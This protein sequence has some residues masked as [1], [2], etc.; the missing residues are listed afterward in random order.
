MR[1]TTLSDEARDELSIRSD[2]SVRQAMQKMNETGRTLLLVV[3]G[4]SLTGVVA[5]GD[6]RRHLA[7]GG[8][9]D[10]P[11]ESAVNRSPITL[12]ASTPV[13]DVRAFMVRRGLEFVPLVANGN[14]VALSILERAPRATD[15]SAVVMAG[16]L[17][18]RLSPLTDDCPKPLLPLDGR[19]ILSHIVEH[20]R[21]QGIHRF[22]FSV[23]HLSNMIV[24]H[25]DDGSRWDCYIDYVH[26]AQRLG[27]GGS[28]SLVDP[29]AL[30]DPFLCVNGDVLSDV[31]IGALRD[32]H[33][34]RSWDATMVVRGYSHTVPYGVVE[35]DDL[36]QYLGLREKPVQSFQVNAGIYM[37]S[38]SVLEIVP[39]NQ[40][41]DLPSVFADLEHAG[42]RG[43]T[44]LHTGRWI[45]IG[46]TSEY[47][48]ARAIF[49]P[50]SSEA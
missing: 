46:T 6:I 19:P 37:L 32:L 7:R 44:Y 43:G 40:F 5:D 21:E 2:A 48:R 38:K 15:M 28:L 23:N 50:E 30:S 4:K 17:G 31:D 8:T 39:R 34:S 25:Y 35:S 27:T 29:E 14:I 22:V 1:L 12:E 24:D 42:L 33:V 3:D 49:E 9:V 13:A 36:G 41:Y 18:T 10:Q 47:N 20:L 11:V 45:D 26:E 16:G